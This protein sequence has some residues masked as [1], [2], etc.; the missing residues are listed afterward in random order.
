MSH[1][2]FLYSADVDRADTPLQDSLNSSEPVEVC[3]AQIPL[4][5]PAMFSPE[6]IQAR[7]Y[8]DEAED[9]DEGEGYLVFIA[10]VGEAIANLE[11]RRPSLQALIE[12]QY[13]SHLEGLLQAL[14][15]A[16]HPFIHLAL[17]DIEQMNDDSMV[18][19]GER[20]RRTLR[21][22]DGDV[23]RPRRGLARY[24]L[25]SGVPGSWQALLGWAGM[26]SGVIAMVPVPLPEKGQFRISGA[27]GPD[28]ALEWGL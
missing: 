21:G 11:R 18:E 8:D 14:R 4:M 6:H 22:L 25:G 16:Q 17:E 20:W 12:A 28:D 1:C 23:P 5:W 9:P 26:A 24:L 27:F 3:G 13:H 2:S 10:P 7:D 15:R 19:A